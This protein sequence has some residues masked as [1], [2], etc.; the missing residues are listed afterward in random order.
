MTYYGDVSI[1]TNTV[2]ISSEFIVKLYRPPQAL[3]Y[4]SRYLKGITYR[5]YFI[6]PAPDVPIMYMYEIYTKKMMSAS[7]YRISVIASFRFLTS[8]SYDRVSVDPILMACV[9]S[10]TYSIG[11]FAK[12]VMSDDP[13]T[14][15]KQQLIDRPLFNLYSQPA[16]PFIG[17]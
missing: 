7:G 4:F 2:S 1:Y 14:V 6:S 16:K 9:P 10:Y 17:R 5:N 11:V 15:A 12:L 3:S 13:G 8:F